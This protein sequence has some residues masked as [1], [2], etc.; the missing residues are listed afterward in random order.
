MIIGE[1]SKLEP[2]MAC[3]TF[4]QEL[5][6]DLLIAF[7][8]TRNDIVDERLINF[9]KGFKWFDQTFGSEELSMRKFIKN[10]E[11]LK[12]ERYSKIVR[13][14]ETSDHFFLLVNGRA[15]ILKEIEPDK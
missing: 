2:C 11:V 8:K 12:L 4:M 1:V 3:E 14:G 9:L 7:S 13:K 6:I 15:S 5:M 10:F